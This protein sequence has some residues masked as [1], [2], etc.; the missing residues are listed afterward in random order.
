MSKVVDFL[1]FVAEKKKAEGLERY[2]DNHE[3]V[4]DLCDEVFPEGAV[5][6]AVDDDELQV[7]STINDSD[8]VC[9]ML[10]AALKSIQSKSEKEENEEDIEM[11]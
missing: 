9:S 5:I 7:S 6:I 8:T 10:F 1:G 2:Y 11:D 3:D 4:L